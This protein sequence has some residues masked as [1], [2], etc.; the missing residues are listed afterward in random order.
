MSS[1]LLM[2]SAAVRGD[3]AAFSAA[4]EDGRRSPAG[5]SDHLEAGGRRPV[6]ALQGWAWIEV[7]IL[8]AACWGLNW[9]AALCQARVMPMGV[10]PRRRRRR[11]GK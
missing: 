9:R 7:M 8:V 10:K 6:A 4:V 2:R 5:S 1:G 11:P 3:S